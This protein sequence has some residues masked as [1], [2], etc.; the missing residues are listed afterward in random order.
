MKIHGVI[1]ITTPIEAAE[2]YARESE[3]RNQ[4]FLLWILVLCKFILVLSATCK[5]FG[6]AKRI[7]S[8]AWAYNAERANAANRRKKFE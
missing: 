6:L 3:E 1:N 4:T 7:A 8:G 2:A 5:A